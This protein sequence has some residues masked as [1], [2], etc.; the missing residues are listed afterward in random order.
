MP[1]EENP[2]VMAAQ[3]NFI[4]GGLL[5]TV[6]AY[7]SVCDV[8]GLNTVLQNGARMTSS[9][10]K[11]S[12]LCTVGPDINHREP[13]MTGISGTNLDQFPEYVLAPTPAAA[14][15]DVTSYQMAATPFKLPD[16][17][18]WIFCFSKS[19]F[20]SLKTATAAYSTSDAL[21][22]LLWRNITLTRVATGSINDVAATALLHP[23]N[24]RSKVSPLL[25]HS[26]TGNA[27]IASITGYMSAKELAA[28]DGLI[29]AA[30]TIRSSMGKLKEPNRVPRLIGLFSSRS[31]RTYFKFAYN[32]F[33]GP[34]LGSTSWAELCVYEME[35]GRLGKPEAFRVR[36]RV[37]MGR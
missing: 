36:G 3:A 8:T 23:G 24:M 17:S 20:T 7:H 13:L 37:Q 18:A 16:M 9:A 22:A 25:P 28:S 2:P 14:S 19:A 29:A 10:S 31:N 6:C 27:S 33:L 26:Y 5:L 4:T 12:S 34:D 15:S 21:H 32:G 1:Q 35:R 30:A 11:D